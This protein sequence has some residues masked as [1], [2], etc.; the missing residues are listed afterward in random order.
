M[1]IVCYY[2][3]KANNVSSKEAENIFSASKK[4]SKVFDPLLKNTKVEFNFRFLPKA[5]SLPLL[6]RANALVNS[7]CTLQILNII[8]L[9]STNFLQSPCQVKFDF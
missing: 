9:S 5:L 7:E 1:I 4:Y 8:C 6:D 3:K 2:W